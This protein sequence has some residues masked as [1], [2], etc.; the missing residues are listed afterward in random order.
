MAE[1]GLN[2]CLDFL[3]R[4]IWCWKLVTSLKINLVG[5]LTTNNALGR[6]SRRAK[7]VTRTVT[8]GSGL[9]AAL[10][11]LYLCLPVKSPFWLVC[12]TFAP[13]LI[14]RKD[15][16]RSTRAKYVKLPSFN[17][18]PGLF[19]GDHH[20]QLRDFAARHPFVKLRHNPVDIGLDLIVRG[21]WKGDQPI[22][23]M[24]RSF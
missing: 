14:N 18:L 5:L 17:V 19:A 11:S 1:Y 4:F 6:P 3:L 10:H 9:T 20:H 15:F 22:K 2:L 16:S 24:K 7:D 21:D 23:W 13:N 8:P 12:C